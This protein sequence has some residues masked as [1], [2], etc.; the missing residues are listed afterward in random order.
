MNEKDL[1]IDIPDEEWNDILGD[2]SWINNLEI[3]ITI[4]GK[5]LG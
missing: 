3:D 5:K 4:P 2:N 1:I